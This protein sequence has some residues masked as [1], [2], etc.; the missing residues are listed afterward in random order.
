MRYKLR[1]GTNNR[2]FYTQSHYILFTKGR[3]KILQ[4]RLRKST[5]YFR[6]FL[7]GKNG[8]KSKIW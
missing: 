3:E 4:P 5:D 6:M 8:L 1:P 2:F 7:F